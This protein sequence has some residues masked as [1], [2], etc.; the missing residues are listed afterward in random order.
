M[1][2]T[3]IAILSDTKLDRE[4]RIWMDLFVHNNKDLINKVRDLTLIKKLTIGSFLIGPGRY[5][6]HVKRI[7]D[8]LIGLPVK[9]YTFL[10][11]CND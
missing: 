8:I 10:S 6:D 3:S 11:F 5:S 4:I 9:L 7:N 2:Q 1:T